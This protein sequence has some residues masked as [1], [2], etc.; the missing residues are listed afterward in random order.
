[1]ESGRLK[2]AFC[3][4]FAFHA[5]AGLLDPLARFLSEDELKRAA[6]Y[7]RDDSRVMFS[8]CR[9]ALRRILSGYL[10]TDPGGIELS[11]LEGGKPVVKGIEFNVSHSEGFCVIAVS[12]VPV[13]IDV[14][15]KSPRDFAGI[16]ARYFSEAEGDAISRSQSPSSLFYRAWCMRESMAKLRGTGVW[17]LMALSPVMDPDALRVV[18]PESLKGVFFREI[19]FDGFCVVVCQFDDVV[20]VLYFPSFS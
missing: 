18:G 2:M 19:P 9:G 10:G 16:S 15:K 3:D 1:M 13:G 12:D 5:E 17:R 6:S 8:V 11:R 14:E 20:P 7:R 4:V